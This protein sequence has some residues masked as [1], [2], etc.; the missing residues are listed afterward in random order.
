MKTRNKI[1][2]AVGGVT[3]AAVLCLAV[4]LFY[5]YRQFS[6][7][8][9][10]DR[11]TLNGL[12]VSCMSVE[13]AYNVVYQDSKKKELML[14]A[15]DTQLV[16]LDASKF[17]EISFDKEAIQRGMDEITFFDYLQ[18][19][20]RNYHTDSTVSFQR[21]NAE[22]YIAEVLSGVSQKKS[23]KAKIKKTQKGF[24]LI[25]EV[26]GTVIN[27][28][29]LVDRMEEEIENIANNTLISIDV[30]EFYNQPKVKAA[31]LKKDYKQLQKYL[32][33]NITYKNSD[34]T[35]NREDIFP[36]LNYKNKKR[37]IILDDSFLRTKVSELAQDLN[38]IGKERRFK[39]T[40]YTR[41]S[42]KA[43]SGKEITVSG[44]T[45]GC[46]VNTEAEYEEIAQLLRKCKSKKN[47]EPVWSVPPKGENG[48]DIGDTYIEISLD[49]Q[50]LWYY[51]D[52]VLSM[53]TDVVTG[54]KNVHDTPTGVYY[55]TERI[56]GKY[57][58]G[59]D[60]KTWVDK[61]MRLTNMGIGLHDAGW[62]GSFGG[63]IYSYNGSHGC[64]NLPKSFA[65]ELY[66]AVFVGLPV[67]IYDEG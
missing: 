63:S 62:R 54:R 60:Y 31:D 38:T 14:M 53:Q 8:L 64:I 22:S 41:S 40:S 49:R 67:I 18:G 35:I 46:L 59:D 57:L 42:R 55:I 7:K 65:Y 61:W 9:F 11:S 36:Y 3:A 12:D 33:W 1:L 39:V 27:Q 25:D 47:R 13:D 6:K 44:G 26:Y 45:Y 51:V 48:D 20:S 32:A 43:H 52:G 28:T 17:C 24:T 30:T 16:V 50:H 21:S 5:Q 10:L 23:K 66:D 4:I 56:N 58:T 2:I 19:K 34:V 29:L 37:E 15:G